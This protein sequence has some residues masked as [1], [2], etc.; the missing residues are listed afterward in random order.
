MGKSV[1]PQRPKSSL[2]SIQELTLVP[3]RGKR[4]YESYGRAFDRSL[5]LSPD[6]VTLMEKERRK[7]NRVQC[8]VVKPKSKK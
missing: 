1:K 2:D 7:K 3:R 8:R 5:D 6:Y 4:P